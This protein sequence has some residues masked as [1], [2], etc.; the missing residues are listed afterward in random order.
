MATEIKCAGCRKHMCTLRDAKVR[1]GMVVYC[2]ECDA[3]NKHL[4]ELAR[5]T[6][7]SDYGMPDFMRGLFGGN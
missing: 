3:R 2:K 4:L 5:S 1:I 6:A 7:A